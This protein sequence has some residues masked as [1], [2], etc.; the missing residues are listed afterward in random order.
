MEL[1]LRDGDYVAGGN[2]LQH[3]SGK[4]ALLQR[5]LFRLT[6]RRGNFPFLPELGSRL[7][8]LSRLPAAQQKSAAEAFVAEALQEETVSVRNVEL[9][10]GEDGVMQLA[11]RLDYEGEE[12]SV[13]M[14][15][16]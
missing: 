5:V 7:W 10:E 4:D 14:T 15:I 12:L 11:V 8:Q 13:A 6:A 16:Q 2:A 1:K 9:R 3:V